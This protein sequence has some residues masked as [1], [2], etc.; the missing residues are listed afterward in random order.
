[1]R[2]SLFSLLLLA[3]TAMPAWAADSSHIELLLF[4]QGD[5]QAN[6]HSKLAPDNWAGSSQHLQPFQLRSSLLENPVSKLVPANGYRVLLHRVWQQDRVNG[7]VRIALSSGDEI[8][9]HHQ[10]EG[11]LTLEQDQTSKV[12]LELWINEFKADG[13][14][15]NSELLQQ[16]A[17]VPSNELTYIDYGDLGVLIRIQPQ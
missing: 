8:F 17:A 10:V 11:V 16:T 12:E 13:N 4:R 15:A 6:Y 14:L 7:P 5:M 1:M 2:K 9:G 3:A